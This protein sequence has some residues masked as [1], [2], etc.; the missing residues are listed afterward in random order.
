MKISDF[1]Y[2][3]PQDRIAD[4]P[5]TERGSTRLLVLDRQ[6]SELQDRHYPDIVDYLSPGDVLILNNTKVI[7]SR[8]FVTKENGAKRE[9]V[10]LERHE[11]DN[12]NQHK[13]MYRGS[14]RV[15][16]KLY[17]D[18]NEITVD[19]V[20]GN[21][22]AVVSSKEDILALTNKYGTVPLPPYMNRDATEQDITRYQTI[23]AKDPGSAAAPTA[24]LN[25]TNDILEKL[26]QKGVIIKYLTLHVGLGT[27]MPIRT[28]NVED[29]EMHSEFF[30]V[31]IDTIEAIQNA[32]KHNSR[33]V[34][35]GTTVARTLEYLKDKLP[36]AVL[37]LSGEADIFI[38]PGYS[39]EIVD[40]LITN[41]HAPKSTVLM[42]A[43]AFSGWD[44]LQTAYT[45]AIDEHYDF[46]SYG[47]SMLIL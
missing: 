36:A 16:D 4:S 20:L 7:K 40:V 28:D 13:V 2:E 5:P 10:I 12:W 24:S 6:K 47:D 35:L 30:V 14:L 21:G 42:L 37:P 26:K 33:I 18:N 43:A 11:H 23:F 17:V 41:F 1:N 22:L 46:L 3:L 9:L 45:H 32:K 27:F 29:H 15:N 8:L 34:A 44:N 39:F 25:M 31:P 19:E 38:F